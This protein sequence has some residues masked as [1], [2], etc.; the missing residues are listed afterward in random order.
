MYRSSVRLTKYH[1]RPL[2]YP[3]VQASQEELVE[4]KQ[5]FAVAEEGV[6]LLQ[7][8]EGAGGASSNLT[9]LPVLLV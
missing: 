9:L 4:Q 1:H 3:R 5:L 7:G 2:L 8:D 6:A